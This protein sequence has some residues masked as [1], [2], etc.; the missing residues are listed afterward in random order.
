MT[1]MLSNSKA[2]YTTPP[3]GINIHVDGVVRPTLTFL[4][5]RLPTRAALNTAAGV[6]VETSRD[7]AD[8]VLDVGGNEPSLCLLDL[9]AAR[10]HVSAED[11]D[12][13]LHASELP[14]QLL[15]VA[16]LC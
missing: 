6:G 1:Y 14:L 16:Y 4:A 11:G 15:D 9:L 13:V 3:L 2:G 7:V 5:L 8:A 10:L 12:F